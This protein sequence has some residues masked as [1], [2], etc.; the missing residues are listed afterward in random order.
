MPTFRYRA[1][2]QV[3]EIVSG[4]IHAP[5][6]AEVAQRI[7]YLGLIPIEAIAEQS[8]AQIKRRAEFFAVLAPARRG[9]DDL[10]RR[11]RAAAAHRRAHQR[12]ARTARGRRRHRPDA[13]DRR[14]RSRRRSC[15]A[16]VSPRRSRAVPTSFR[17]SMSRWCGSAKRRATL[18]ADPR[19][20]RARSASAP[21][22]CAAGCATRCAIRRS[23]CSPPAACCCSSCSSCCR[24]SPMCFA[25]STP[26]ST[27]CSS[28]SSALSEFLR[29]NAQT[30]GVGSGRFLLAALLASRRPRRAP[31]RASAL[32]AAAACSPQSIDYHRTTL[33]LPQSRPAAVERRDADDSLRILADMMAA[34]GTPRRLDERRRPGAPRR[35][36]VGRAGG[37]R[38]RCRPWRCARCGSARNRASCRCSP[39]HRRLST[40][41]SCSAASTARRDRR[42][43]RDHRHQPDRRRPYRFGDDGAAVGQPGRRIGAKR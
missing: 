11:S 42:A 23:C 14:P 10:H 8:E 41:R 2:T 18:V 43:A 38:T 27:R 16:R 31:R 34:T 29:A 39:A 21:R 37:R 3:G 12:S 4:S 25:T 30:V 24:N 22:R 13:A 20:A 9:R 15:P 6:A 32:R 19:S 28:R 36:A 1:L 17:R 35:Q 7:E 33:V 26:S 40:R 5:S